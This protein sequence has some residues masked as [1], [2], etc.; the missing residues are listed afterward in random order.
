MISQ[1]EIPMS[2]NM[3]NNFTI[4]IEE[5]LYEKKTPCGLLAVYETFPFGKLL[6]IDGQVLI[7]ESD[8]FFYYEM[9]SHSVLFTHEEPQN[10]LIIGNNFG[11]LH[12][13]LKHPS[14]KQVL[15]VSDNNQLDEA[16]SQYFSHLYPSTYDDRV[17]H[18]CAE[19]FEWLSQCKDNEFD[20][21]I[22]NQ[23]IED[24]Q[25]EL[26]QNKYHLLRPNGI[27]V[28]PCFS[29]MLYLNKLKIIQQNIKNA[30]FND[31]QIL[32]FPQP[33]YP[34]GLRTIMMTT[35]QRVFERVREKDIYN[36]P[37]TTRYYNFDV[38]KAALV[39]PE[40]MR[41]ELDVMR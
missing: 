2:G 29:S 6:S 13:V 16:I 11:I 5:K 17:E 39:L 24:I 14:I 15:C 9:M 10:V 31:W 21:I 25:E 3:I 41:R 27:L 22:Q 4:K 19:P 8:S 28:A 30:G 26:Y 33:S 34:S 7:S 38:H 35:K 18:L 37:F 32:N 23:Q 40:F 12:E 1:R 36:R 20:I